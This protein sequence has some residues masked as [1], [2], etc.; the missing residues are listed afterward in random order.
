MPYTFEP[1]ALEAV[2]GLYQSYMDTFSGEVDDFWEEQALRARQYII[3]RDGTRCGLFAV[4]DWEGAPAL[5]AFYLAQPCWGDAQRVFRQVRQTHDI[6][7]ALV[8]TCDELFLSLS[9]DVH[10]R[11]KLQAYFFDGTIAPQV[12]PPEYPRACLSPMALADLL[13]MREQTG[14]FFDDCTEADYRQ[15]KFQLYQLSDGGR[16]LGYGLLSFHHLRRDNCSLGMITLP[17]HRGKGV[18]RSIQYHLGEICREMGKRPVSGCWYGN[19]AS[20][21]TQHSA[22]RYSK[23]R[24][25]NILL[26]EPDWEPR[27]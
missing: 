4:A 2:D 16:V 27:S 18:G 5:T 10:E 20:R 24:Y 17:E 23:T 12:R 26:H 6:R 11:V 25:L 19:L 3:A 9:L 1:A 7:R 22:G 21:D 15:G 14:D 8:A 13:R